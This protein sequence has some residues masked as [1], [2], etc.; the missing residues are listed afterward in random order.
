MKLVVAKCIG[1]Y[2]NLL[3]YI[4]P[5]DAARLAI[6]LFSKPRK[7]KHTQ[8]AHDFLNTAFQEE[9]FFNGTSIMTYRWPG[10]HETILLVHGWE[11]NAFRWEALINKLRLKNHNIVAVDAPGHG[12]SGSKSFNIIDYSEYLKVVTYKFN[13]QAIIAHSFGGMATIFFQYKYQVPLLKK[14]VLLGAPSNLEDVIKRYTK[15]MGFNT[16]VTNALK[17]FYL[18]HFGHSPEYYHAAKFTKAIKTRG[19]IIH[20]PEDHIIPYRD[21]LEYQAFYPNVKLITTENL[22]HSLKSEAVDQHILE[23]I[24]D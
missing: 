10:I 14:I 13:V 23:F 11:S 4:A 21:A 17:A 6:S 24:A 5:N 19:L 20:D 7:G 16:I 8:E 22:D 15:M 12:K 3:G 1:L 2:I 9:V 18:Q